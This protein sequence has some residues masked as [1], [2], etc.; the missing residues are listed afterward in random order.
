[1]SGDSADTLSVK[2]PEGAGS[3]NTHSSVF[4]AGDKT[5]DA[6]DVVVSGSLFEANLAFVNADTGDI[7]DVS[8][9]YGSGR[10]QLLL[11]TA[12]QGPVVGALLCSSVGDTVVTE[13]SPQDSAAMGVD[14][15]LIVVAEINAVYAPRAEGKTRAL[16]TGFPAVTNDE[17]GR[18]G[19]VLPPQQAPTK[20]KSS[21]RIEG[22]GDKVASTDNVIGNVLTVSWE[23]QVVRNTWDEM[24]SG[25]GAEGDEGQTGASFRAELTGYPV[26]SQVVIIEPTGDGTARVSVV[27]ILAVL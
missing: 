2:V 3:M 27:D 6:S 21:V 26:G 20:V 24:P 16:T 8:P 23:G 12:E 18:P 14:G 4:S 5:S 9:A 22:N 1:M 10:G 19:M 15:Q 13:L 11:A 7:L 17:T 25:F